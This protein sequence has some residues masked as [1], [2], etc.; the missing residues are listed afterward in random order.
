MYGG[1][2]LPNTGAAGLTLFGVSVGA[3]FWLMLTLITLAAVLFAAGR[4]VPRKEV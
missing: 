3:E 4:M 2:T 1:S